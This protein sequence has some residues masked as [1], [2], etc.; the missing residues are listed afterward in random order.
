MF[1]L[2]DFHAQIL[3]TLAKP[4]SLHQIETMTP[5]SL[6][7]AAHSVVTSDVANLNDPPSKFLH[8]APENSPDIPSIAAKA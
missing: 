3:K 1:R 5:A 4:P 6:T 2:V 7:Q 8:Q